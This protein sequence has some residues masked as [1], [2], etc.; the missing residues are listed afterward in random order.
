VGKGLQIKHNQ[1]RLENRENR[2][3]LN[4][5]EKGQRPQKKKER[6]RNAP[7]SDRANDRGKN[8]TWVWKKRGA[9]KRPKKYTVEKRK[10]GGEKERKKKS[11]N[12]KGRKG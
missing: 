6:V 11:Q 12:R 8:K 10:K 5:N 1:G 7:N 9:P 3:L 2:W 4:Q